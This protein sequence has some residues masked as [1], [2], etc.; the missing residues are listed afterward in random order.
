MRTK[1]EK[2][3]L[4]EFIHDN[5]QLERLEEIIGEF[6]IFTALD[7]INNEIRH[8]N[9]LSWL[10]NPRESHGLGDY[11][12]TS[13]LKK[14]AYKA[15]S[16]GIEGPSIFDIDSWNFN[17]AD[18]LR[19]WMNIDILVKSD[20]QR[21]A[22]IVENKIYSKEHSKQ[23]RRYR[24]IAEKEYADYQK[25]FVYLT[26]EG[27][28]PSEGEYI[29][30]SYSEI[31]PL[32]EHLIESKKNKLGPDILTFISHYGEMLR[33]YIME[34]SEIQ[35]I[36]RKIYKAHRDALELIFEYKPDRLSDI[37][38][39]LVEMIDKDPDLTLDDSTK[40]Y[41]RFIPKTMDFIPK[42]GEGWTKT[43]RILL[44][45]FNN[46]PKG[47]DLHLIIGP[48]QQEIREKIYDIAKGNLGVFNRAKRSLTKV[49]FRV[50][51]KSFLRS[52]EYEDKEVEEIR[53]LLEKRFERFK[54]SDL[55]KIENEIEKLRAHMELYRD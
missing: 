21:F 48:G 42:R 54:T 37:K 1:S 2:E 30:L 26:V 3:I 47:V 8:S 43:K 51:A 39:C 22:C 50:Y 45:E 15:S 12:L 35:K 36:C 13:F 25:L 16:L 52:R 17:D 55:P 4:E 7:I 40:S 6:N 49:W 29:P 14:V 10:I 44:F 31:V 28:I 53:R 5:A 20:S 24:E 27:D 38:E 23:L 32:V 11:F 41:I 34:D 18:V 19:E 46:N 9:F 33:R